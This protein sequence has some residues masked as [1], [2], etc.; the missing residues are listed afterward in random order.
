MNFGQRWKRGEEIEFLL[1][2]WKV[3]I[4]TY[5]NQLVSPTSTRVRMSVGR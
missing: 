1:D 3:G 4:D 5:P 2:E